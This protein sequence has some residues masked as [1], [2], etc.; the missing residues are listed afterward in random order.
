MLGLLQIKARG[1][2]RVL[3]FYCPGHPTPILKYHKA[4]S[5]TCWERRKIKKKMLGMGGSLNYSFRILLDPCADLLVSIPTSL[6]PIALGI[7][8]KCLSWS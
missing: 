8:V 5:D 4:E 6:L 2:C 3:S 7:K 1:F